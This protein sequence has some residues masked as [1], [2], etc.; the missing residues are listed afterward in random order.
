MAG[1]TGYV[2][3]MAVSGERNIYIQLGCR[4]TAPR[5]QSGYV[6]GCRPVYGGSNPSLGSPYSIDFCQNLTKKVGVDFEM[7]RYMK[8]REKL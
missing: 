4:K 6:T 8:R 5:C 2:G 1:L 3:I 7:K